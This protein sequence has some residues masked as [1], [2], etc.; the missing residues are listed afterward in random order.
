MKDRRTRSRSSRHNPAWRGRALV[1]ATD[2]TTFRPRPGAQVDGIA[3]D[4]NMVVRLH[5]NA[6]R[7]ASPSSASTIRDKAYCTSAPPERGITKPGLIIVGAD[8]HLHSRRGCPCRSARAL[9]KYARAGHG[10]YGSASLPRCV[11]AV[12]GEAGFGVREDVILAIIARHRH[13][14][15]PRME[16]SA[17]STIRR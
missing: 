4:R 17:G 3:A 10:S 9:R 6:A 1:F 13:R 14:K 2:T 15:A 16:S 7:R 12:Q 8:S 11:A 5:A